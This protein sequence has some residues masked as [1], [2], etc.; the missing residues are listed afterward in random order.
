M[1]ESE[2]PSENPPA[3]RRRAEVATSA[4]EA[5]L[6]GNSTDD[7]SA[8]AGAA[9]VGPLL[10]DIAT[11]ARAQPPGLQ[12]L[13]D[14]Y[15]YFL[16]EMAS[17]CTESLLS[18]E[19]S[20]A[21][22]KETGADAVAYHRSDDFL[23]DWAFLVGPNARVVARKRPPSDIALV[24][25]M[26]GEAIS[27]KLAGYAERLAR[28][29]SSNHSEVTVVP[30]PSPSAHRFLGLR[31]DPRG[32]GEA[33]AKRET[34]SQSIKARVKA[35]QMGR[36]DAESSKRL[37]ERSTHAA[38]AVHES[39]SRGSESR[40]AFLP[41]EE[42]PYAVFAAGGEGPLLSRRSPKLIP[43]LSDGEGVKAASNSL[44]PKAKPKSKLNG[45]LKGKG[46]KGAK[47]AQRGKGQV[48]G[49][50]RQAAEKSVSVVPVQATSTTRCRAASDLGLKSSLCPC[51]CLLQIRNAT[52]QPRGGG[53]SLEAEGVSDR[54]FRSDDDALSDHWSDLE[55]EKL[56][57]EDEWERPASP[58]SASAAAA[59]LA[60]GLGL[61]LPFG[62][63]KQASWEPRVCLTP[64]AHAAAEV[65]S[66]MIYD[67]HWQQ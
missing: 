12:V 44:I 17:A 3:K 11:Y 29:T 42:S 4:A 34:A 35:L 36:L 55:E 46:A 33:M 38:K 39:F 27:T 37:R 18:I 61:G 22:L 31:L 45:G 63:G 64:R 7:A 40:W 24:R 52:R 58:L 43:T 49:Q 25:G 13:I 51:A 53:L 14:R 1:E 57:E 59:A 54:A 65:V 16:C 48:M 56:F 32:T 30:P 50:R 6:G 2:A 5:G 67:P 60:G 66:V 41:L 8:Q 21:R 15:H 23:T 26:T 10:A 28:R 62:L 47:G 20:I 9:A 19:G